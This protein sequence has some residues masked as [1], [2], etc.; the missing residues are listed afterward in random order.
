MNKYSFYG[1]EQIRPLYGLLVPAYQRAF[2]GWPWR[3]VSKCADAKQRCVGGMSPLA[4]GRYCQMC[5]SCTTR[6]AY[7]ADE[8][9]DRFDRLAALRP[10]S[11]FVEGNGQGLNLFAMAWRATPAQIAEEKY[12]DVPEMRYWLEDNLG[13][14]PI[15]WLDEVFADKQVQAAGNLRN[16]K[17]LCEGFLKQL[18]GS[19][20]A[21]RTI[22]PQMVTAAR[23]N[24][25]AA[26]MVEVPDRRN[27]IKIDQQEVL[28]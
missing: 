6:P 21:Y 4:V 18:G 27:F 5:E 13:N 19:V 25:G 20:L 23:S 3:E 14:E 17:P 15:I 9:R 10:V 24:F 2:A 22:T 8:L 28:V 11:W 1:G 12:S 26:P 16:F 7:E